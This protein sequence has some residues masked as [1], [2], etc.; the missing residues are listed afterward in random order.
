MLQH[1]IKNN[2]IGNRIEGIVVEADTEFY[3]IAV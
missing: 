2:L 3:D 1:V